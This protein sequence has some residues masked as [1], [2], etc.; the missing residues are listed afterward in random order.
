MGIAPKYTFQGRNIQGHKAFS[1]PVEEGWRM[2][3]EAMKGLSD[4]CRSR[5]IM[6]TKWGKMEIVSVIDGIKL[7]KKK[8]GNLPDGLKEALA[9]GFIIFKS[10]RSPYHAEDQ[11]D[12]IIARQNP[13]ALWI[14]GYE[15]RIIYDTRKGRTKKYDGLI[16]MMLN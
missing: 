6:S 15:D 13:E 10:Y 5:F 9:D 1:L 11:G 2:H 7:P 4:A 3:N 14:S 12:L 16:N 8:A